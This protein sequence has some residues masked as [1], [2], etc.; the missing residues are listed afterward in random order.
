LYVDGRAHDCAATV[1]T[2][3]NSAIACVLKSLIVACF[4]H[5]NGLVARKRPRGGNCKQEARPSRVYMS[6][7][8][9]KQKQIVGI[10]LHWQRVNS[11]DPPSMEYR[12]KYVV[13]PKLRGLCGGS[14]AHNHGT[15]ISSGRA[16]L[17]T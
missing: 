3:A 13:L 2:D 4:P 12:R 11:K 17:G 6:L 8:G 5:K 14:V 16:N 7:C 15:T 1:P 9:Q 10:S